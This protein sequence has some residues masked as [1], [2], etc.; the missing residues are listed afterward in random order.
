MLEL[1]ELSLW[2]NDTVRFLHLHLCVVYSL[3]PDFSFGDQNAELIPVI[4]TN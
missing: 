1:E 3:A 2:F 4:S